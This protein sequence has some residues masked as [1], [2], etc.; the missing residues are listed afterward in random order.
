MSVIHLNK[1]LQHINQRT[2]KALELDNKIRDLEYKIDLKVFELY[3]L[4]ENDRTTIEQFL[5]SSMSTKL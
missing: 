1:E 2:D 3:G 4:T 5:K